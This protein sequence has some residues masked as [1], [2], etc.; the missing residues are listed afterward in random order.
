VVK[1]VSHYDVKEEIAASN[2]RR[3]SKGLKP[4]TLDALHK[5]QPHELAQ[6][7]KYDQAHRLLPNLRANPRS[8]HPAMVGG[9]DNA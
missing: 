7:L 6:H 2:V 8:T 1:V 9:K 5:N 4:I 3:S